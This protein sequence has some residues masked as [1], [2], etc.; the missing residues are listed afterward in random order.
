MD[1]AAM[2]EVFGEFL[3][4][5]STLLSDERVIFVF[6]NAAAHRNP[7]ALHQE[8]HV[9]H[10]LPMYSPF[11]NSSEMAGSAFKARIKEL[12]SQPGMQEQFGDVA[13]Q[14]TLHQYR[15]R[16]LH[17]LTEEANQTVTA[18]KCLAWYNHTLAY[19][20]RCIREEDIWA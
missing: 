19:L 10:F 13:A 3:I 8:D 16:I 12:L 11:L 18:D 20:P 14:L 17:Q 6:D 1:G 7:V 2:Q 5:L 4:E 9:I 15:L